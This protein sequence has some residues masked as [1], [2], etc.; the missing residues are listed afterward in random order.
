MI[1][2]I[3]L[4]LHNSLFVLAG[5]NVVGFFFTFLVPESKGKSLEELSGENE[6]DE[7]ET[8]AAAEYRAAPA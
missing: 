2:L 5:C 7:V 3:F 6:D 1:F 4:Y 8:S